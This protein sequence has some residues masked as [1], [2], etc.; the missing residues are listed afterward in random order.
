MGTAPV[1][2]S[3]AL[4]EDI[5]RMISSLPAGLLGIRDRALLQVGSAGAFRRS[6]LVGLDFED[7][8]F[9]KEGLI[10]PFSL[11]ARLGRC[12]LGQCLRFCLSPRVL[13]FSLLRLLRLECSLEERLK[14]QWFI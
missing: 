4:T 2:K 12:L 10:R 9:G 7:C 11:L 3:P 8:I 14:A 5:R 13:P 6:E 1:V